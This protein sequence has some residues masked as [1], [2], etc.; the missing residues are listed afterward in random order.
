MQKFK[1]IAK[2]IIK[3]VVYAAILYI[4]LNLLVVITGVFLM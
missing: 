4:A 3:T 2:T 1:K